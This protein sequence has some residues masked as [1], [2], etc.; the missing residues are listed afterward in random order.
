MECGLGGGGGERERD[1]LAAV[2]SYDTVR[3]GLSPNRSDCVALV[4]VSHLAAERI[5]K[6]STHASMDIAN[7]HGESGG[8][9]L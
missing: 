5:Q 7:R 9:A 4:H 2:Y 8:S 3:I 1:K 6:A